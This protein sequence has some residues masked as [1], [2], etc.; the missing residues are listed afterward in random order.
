[1]KDR[2]KKFWNDHKK[3]A[4]TAAFAAGLGVVTAL[5]IRDATRQGPI[6]EHV[7][8]TDIQI[9]NWTNDDGD[10]LTVITYAE[11]PYELPGWT[12]HSI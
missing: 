7:A 8:N 5:V 1:M 9:D 6:S 2:L 10:G 12:P 11:T 4:P 3:Y